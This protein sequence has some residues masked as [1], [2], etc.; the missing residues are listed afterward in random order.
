MSERK[1][2]ARIA[3]PR[4]PPI[5]GGI[6]KAFRHRPGF[7]AIRNIRHAQKVYGIA[8]PTIV[9]KGVAKRNMKFLSDA[10]HDYGIKRVSDKAAQAAQAIIEARI[11]GDL[12][13]S[14]VI[15]NRRDA[16]TTK[17]KDLTGVLAIQDD[18]NY[19]KMQNPP[20]RETNTENHVNVPYKKSKKSKKK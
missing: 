8:K 10:D 18:Y 14:R 1:S 3:E 15:T 19:T 4:E 20:N 6:K 16:H 13:E 7:Q 12:R 11:I 9:G 2:L 5:V 17:N